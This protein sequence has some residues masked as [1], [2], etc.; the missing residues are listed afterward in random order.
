MLVKSSV[1]YYVHIY[2]YIYIY[3]EPLM[4][5]SEATMLTTGQCLRIYI[6]EFAHSVSLFYLVHRVCGV[7][8]GFFLFL[9]FFSSPPRRRCCHPVQNKLV[10]NRES[11][12][13]F[14]KGKQVWFYMGCDL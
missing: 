9:P 7:L 8:A 2:K 1:L 4:H 5:T 13:G 11:K 10:L 3:I 12:L 6:C 14:E